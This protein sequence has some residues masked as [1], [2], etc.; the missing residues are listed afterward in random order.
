M[1]RRAALLAAIALSAAA[2]AACGDGAGEPQTTPTLPADTPA[3]EATATPVDEPTP[4][5]RIPAVDPATDLTLPAGFTAYAIAGDFIRATSIA[6]GPNNE[7]YVSERHGNVYRLLDVDG[8]GVFE[9]RLTFASGFDEVTGIMAAPDGAVYVSG[10]RA[11]TVVRDT[12][13][14]GVG[15]ASEQII[16]GLPNGRHKNNGMAIGP[17]GKLYLTN[18]STCDDCVEADP[19]SAAILQANLDGSE[20]RVYARGLRNPYDLAFDSQGRLWATDNGSDEPCATV[21]ELNLVVDGGDYGW[22]YGADGCDPFADGAPPVASLGLH[23][24]STGIDVYEAEHFPAAYRGVFATVWGSL[25]ATPDPYDRVLLRVD[26]DASPASVEEFA[27]GFRHPIDVAVDSDGTLLVLDYGT[28][29][30]EAGGGT[31]YRIVHSGE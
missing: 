28:E 23:T 18:G 5:V 26:V 27:S 19:L 10:V 24:A 21:D 7:L 20:L 25:F 2:L 1:P 15:D 12:D 22:P 31:L 17:D 8:D 14:D 6:L 16:S 4:A 13:G 11:V 30:A 9:E 29:A 3:P